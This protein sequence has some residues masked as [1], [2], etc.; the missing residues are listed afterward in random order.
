MVRPAG[1]NNPHLRYSK[2][3]GSQVPS[4]KSDQVKICSSS[5]ADKNMLCIPQRL[6]T[7]LQNW[8]TAN[9][10]YIPDKEPRIISENQSINPT[11]SL[12]SCLPF[13]KEYLVFQENSTGAIYAEDCHLRVKN[14]SAIL[15]AA[16]KGWFPPISIISLSMN[17]SFLIILIILLCSLIVLGVQ[18]EGVYRREH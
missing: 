7:V 6:I 16:C 12:A 1:W 2:S 13:P 8:R 15:T 4:V 11:T 14:P 17:F 10:M 18:E 5:A 9:A 3:S